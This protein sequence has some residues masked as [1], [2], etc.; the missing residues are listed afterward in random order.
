MEKER[1]AHQL[2]QRLLAQGFETYL[3]GGCVRDKVRGVPPKDFDI[4]TSAQPEVVQ[5]TFEK[6]IPVGVQFGVILV[7][8]QGHTFEVATFRSDGAY[9]DGRHPESITFSTVEADSKRR[10]FTVNGM[11]LDVRTGQVVDLVGG[12]E[13]LSRRLIRTIGDPQ[14]RFAEDRLRML[15]AVRFAA[16]LDFKM[17]PPC[18][19]AIR[20]NAHDIVSVSRERIQG[21]IS[22]ILTGPSPGNGFRLLDGVGLLE[23]ILPEMVAMKGVEQPA[24][25]HPEGDV[26]THT[27][28]LLDQL[29]NAPLELA[30]GALLHD[31]AKP[32]TFDRATDR[33][34]FHGHDRLGAEMS[35]DICRRFA[36][37]NDVLNLVCALVAEHLKFKDVTHMRLSTLKRFVGTPRFD[38]HLELHKIDCKAS[39]GKMDA[40]DFCQQKLKEFS[41]L[42]PPPL[43]LVTGDDLISL[44]H[45][46]GPHFGKILRAVEDAILEGE[47]KEKSQAL[48][49]IRKNHPRC[50]DE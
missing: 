40:Y 34:R 39:H 8:E 32:K 44:G 11:Y 35:R 48:E 26:Y 36:Y 5:K 25:Y 7:I 41:A 2:V 28:L 27:L 16:Q 9:Q 24:E 3:A 50:S 30:L 18:V 14:Q 12:R 10:D 46:P 37:P 38:L 43:R 6:T 45:R 21:E 29:S 19:S 23:P 49:W 22:K 17:D 1:I 20:A 4:A 13:D 42:P 33:I 47:I 15:R 31:V